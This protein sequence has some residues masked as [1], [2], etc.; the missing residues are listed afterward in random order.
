MKKQEIVAGID[1]GGTTTKIGLVSENGKIIDRAVIKTSGYL[2][3]NEYIE[4]LQKE[5]L[6]LLPEEY[7]LKGIGIGAPNGNIFRGTV[8][9]AANLEWKGVIPVADLINKKFKLPVKL[10]NDANAAALGEKLFGNG[11]NTDNFMMITLGTGLGGGIV[12]DGKLLYGNS[13]FAGEPGHITVKE[14]GRQCGCGRKGCLETYVSATGLLKTAKE[15]LSDTNKESLMR[16]V[17]NTDLTSKDV[18]EFAKKGDKLALEVFDYT[19]EIFGKALANFTVLLSPEKFILFGGLAEAGDLL[20]NLTEK[21]MNENL[22][23]V[24]RNTV[25][26]QKSGLNSGDAAIM[27]AAALIW[28]NM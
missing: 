22:M 7:A 10:T 23:K 4:S 24:F 26:I 11:K 1:I 9:Y 25:S 6:K 28:D 14:N 2:D 18:Y 27:G 17:K 12:A 3:I 5:I 20:L 15:F 16:N 8:E 13:G 19:A 21:Y